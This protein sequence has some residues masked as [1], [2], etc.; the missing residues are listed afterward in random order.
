MTHFATG[1]ET[2]HKL[3]DSRYRA[4]ESYDLKTIGLGLN[5]AQSGVGIVEYG[6]VT[7]LNHNFVSFFFFCFLFLFLF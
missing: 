2:W 1:G 7:T 5:G 4:G 3:T 6:I